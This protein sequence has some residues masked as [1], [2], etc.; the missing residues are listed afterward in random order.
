MSRLLPITAIAVTCLSSNFASATLVTFFNSS[1]IATP[2]SSG[3][4]SETIQSNG[5]QFTYT[6][7]KL[8]TGGTGVPIGRTER[9]PWP[10]GVEAQSVTTPPPGVTDYKARITL[11]R[12]D[13]NVFDLTSFTARLLANT[14]GAGG[15]IE[16]MPLL[17]G[18]DA[19]NDPIYFNASGYYWQSFSYDQTPNYLG[20]TALLKG[21]DTYKVNLYVDFAF[22]ALTLEDPSVAGDF[23]DDQLVDAADIDLLFAA[24]P[25]TVPPANTI[26][27]L[28]NDSHVI[29]TPNAAASDADYWVRTIASTD[30]G[31]TN[32]DGLINFDDLLALAQHY[33]TTTGAG[34]AMGNTN[35]DGAVDFDDLL[36]LAQNYRS[37][38][39][40]SPTFDTDF[41]TD[42]Q[43]ALSMAPEPAL[44]LALL[45]VLAIASRRSPG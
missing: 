11:K 31:D 23:N 21:F 37:A 40:S 33:G 22:T 27:D 10:V 7:D 25:G 34:W 35:G 12:V 20:S 30:Y 38:V 42:W 45:G 14:A 32:L 18:E 17:N 3:V 16:I 15:S 4:T 19:F 29:I 43:L 8:F 5:Y 13:G 1:Q 28:N 44:P 36:V 41:T 39:I 24:L 9:I 26:F 2:V 6:R